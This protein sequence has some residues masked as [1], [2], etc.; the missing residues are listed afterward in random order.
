M[1]YRENFIDKG[2]GS[3]SLNKRKALFNQ[4]QTLHEGVPGPRAA[5]VAAVKIWCPDPDPLMGKTY[6]GVRCSMGSEG[7]YH[8]PCPVSSTPV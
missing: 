4:L 1:Y 5:Y 6:A 3:Q 7:A 2:N 8:P